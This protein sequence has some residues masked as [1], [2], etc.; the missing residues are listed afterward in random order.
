MLP[1]IRWRISAL[2]CSTSSALTIT[3][4]FRSDEKISGTYV[5]QFADTRADL[6]S[7]RGFFRNRARTFNNKGLAN[8]Y[9][10]PKLAYRVVK[11]IYAGE[12]DPFIWGSTLR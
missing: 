6:R 3:E 9:R 5:W 2:E 1:C 7:N 12:V 10:K 11:G 4:H 8:E